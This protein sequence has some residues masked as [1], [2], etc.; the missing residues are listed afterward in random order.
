MERISDKEFYEFL[1]EV[2]LQPCEPEYGPYYPETKTMRVKTLYTT[3]RKRYPELYELTLRDFAKGFINHCGLELYHPE[4]YWGKPDLDS[5]HIRG[6]MARVAPR[7]VFD[8]IKIKCCA[9]KE[10]IPFD[11]AY[12]LVMLQFEE[13]DVIT[14]NE[15]RYMLYNFYERMG[16]IRDAEVFYYP[17]LGG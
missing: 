7:A 14:K 6:R 4:G 1:A 9:H 13:K 2:Y 5:L 8:I 17:Q 11:E 16:D 3:I 12:Q 10:A 15:Y